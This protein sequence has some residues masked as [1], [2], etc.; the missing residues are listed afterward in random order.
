MKSISRAIT[1]LAL[2]LYIAASGLCEDIYE[3][4]RQAW[5]EE[6]LALQEARGLPLHF[7]TV[8]QKHAVHEKY[9]DTYWPE[10]FQ[11]EPALPEDGDLREE[12]AM[13]IAEDAIRAKY[14]DDALSLPYT[15]R[16]DVNFLAYHQEGRREW[17]IS[18]YFGEET[19]Y[20]AVFTVWLDGET[21]TLLQDVDGGE[22]GRG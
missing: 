13:G 10:G 1:G 16:D 21:G 15:R 14:G 22:N 4:T 9:R 7:W 3:A 20:K 8:A 2:A 11:V 6:V 18:I 19:D 12:A 17:R 5:M